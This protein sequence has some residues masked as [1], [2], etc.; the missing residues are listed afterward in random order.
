MSFIV[1]YNGQLSPYILPVICGG[2]Q[3]RFNDAKSLPTLIAAGNTE[4]QRFVEQTLSL[5][6]LR[7]EGV[8]LT[9]EIKLFIFDMHLLLA[10]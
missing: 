1:S 4:R 10:K 7:A 5:E 3:L 6:S 8:I 9:G 2:F